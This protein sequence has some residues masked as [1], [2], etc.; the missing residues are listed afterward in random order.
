MHSNLKMSLACLSI[1]QAAAFKA[2][3][4]QCVQMRVSWPIFKKKNF[5]QFLHSGWR[6]N[7]CSGHYIW[8]IKAMINIR[9][10]LHWARRQA[11]LRSILFI[12]SKTCIKYEVEI[13]DPVSMKV[14]RTA[15][16]TWNECDKYMARYLRRKKKKMKDRY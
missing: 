14:K 5:Y 13:V 1:I 16:K 10:W 8:L 15:Q 6:L 11:M 3:A 4:P 12:L 2:N 7:I 9:T